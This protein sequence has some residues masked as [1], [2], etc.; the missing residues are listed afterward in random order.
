[1]R[2]LTDSECL[3]AVVGIVCMAGVM[4]KALALIGRVYAPSEEDDDS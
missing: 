4:V 2:S 3:V 1:M